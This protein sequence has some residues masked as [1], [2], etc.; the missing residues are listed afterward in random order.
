MATNTAPNHNQRQAI[1]K[2]DAEI[3]PIDTT[4]TAIALIPSTLD[5]AFQLAAWLATSSF[6]PEKL[7][8]KPGDVFAI[9]LAGVELGLPPMAALRGL[10]IVNGKVAAEGRT[11]AAVC[12]QRGAAV[13]IRRTEYT[14]AASTWETLR[15]GATA[16]VTM[17]YTL[18]EAN[19]AGLAGKDGPWRAFPQRMIS[20]RAL[21]W[22]L[23]DTYPDILMGVATAEDFDEEADSAAATMQALPAIAVVSAP[24]SAAK[25][26][27]SSTSAPTKSDK[28]AALEMSVEERDEIAKD[29]KAC[30][31][32]P[33]V[34][35]IM[36]KRIAPRA[37]SASTREWLKQ[38]CGEHLDL[39]EE[40]AKTEREAAGEQP[41][42]PQS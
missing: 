19:K 40:A 33:A 32:K 28:P 34:Q 18:D 42:G 22:L 30:T 15:R 6:L 7:R 41:E 11:K 26:A 20:H 14:P 13:Y 16:P 25:S 24:P 31:T 1:T 38:V 4:S 35:D 29:V 10:Y 12:L 3:T 17:R 9:V 39:I 37:M 36:R 23:D 27:A 21:G 5:G 2:V 8:N